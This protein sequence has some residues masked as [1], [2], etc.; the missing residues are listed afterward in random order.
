MRQ[1][2]VTL[3]GLALLVL[4]AVA[5]AAHAFDW[6]WAQEKS[7]PPPGP[8]HPIVS[9]VV[10][11]TDAY[12]RSVPGVI[13]ARTEVALGFQTLGRMVLRPVD[14]GDVVAAGD[15]LAELNPDDLQ[16]DVRAAEAAA[17]ATRVQLETARSTADRTRRLS[18]R[19]VASTAQLE[20]AEQ[21]LAS[22]QA[23]ADQ[24]AS[25]LV[26]AQDAAGFARMTAPFD[27]IVSQVFKNPGAVVSAGEPV[28]RLSGNDEREAVIDLPEAAL[29]SVPAG[30]GFIVF[31]DAGA[32]DGVPATVRQIDPLADAAT[33][34]RRVHL[35]LS[36]P[37]AFRLGA[38]IR[39]RPAQ[40]EKPALTLP[41]EALR[42]DP[43]GTQVWVVTRQ[44]D[45]ATVNLRRVETGVQIGARIA[46]MSGLVPGDEVVI[47]GIHS[48]EPGQP[49]GRKVAP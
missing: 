39:A 37:D 8:P 17:Q 1:L 43:D 40:G 41:V 38:L 35:K 33:R 49:V 14:I 10:A 11:D 34:T 46:I 22:A 47:R 44:G 24:A 4:L 42:H 15:V 2:F 29:A 32:T 9:E 23:A 7:A 26:R 25:Q 18:I 31:S 48:L 27:G 16:A 36:R 12:A 5:P 3:T 30:A 21:G 19:N 45:A 13:A 28:L 6:P 20:A